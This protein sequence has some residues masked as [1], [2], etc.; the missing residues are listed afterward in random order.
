PP[1]LILLDVKMPEMDGY[2]VCQQLQ[3]HPTTRTI[4]IIFVTTKDSPDDVVRG[5]SL[6]AV[7]F[8]TKPITPAIVRARVKT[9]LELLEA[10]LKKILLEEKDRHLELARKSN[11]LTSSMLDLA[12]VRDKFD[13]ITRFA[14][15]TYGVDLCRVWMFKP[16]AVGKEGCPIARKNHI[17]DECRQKGRCIHLMSSC[18]NEM[19]FEDDREGIP[20]GHAQMGLITAREEGRFISNDLANDPTFKAGPGVVY[21]GLAAIAGFQL[22]N[23]QG[24]MV[25]IMANFALHPL[26]DVT[27]TALTQLATL[28]SQVILGQQDREEIEL[29]MIQAQA[30]SRAKTAFLATMS[31]EIRTPMNA[32]IGMASILLDTP[33]DER[34]KSYL[35]RIVRGAHTLLSVVNDILD[36]SKMEAGKMTLAQQPFDPGLLVE[37]VCS[38]LS[39]AV[40]QKGLAFA[41]QVGVGVPDLLLGDASR[42]KQIVIN[43]LGNAIKFTNSGEIVVR[44]TVEKENGTSATSAHANAVALHFLVADSGVGIPENKF[45]A[46]FNSFEQVENFLT[47]RHGGTGL[48]LSICTRLVELMGGRIW[49]ESKEGEGSQFHFTVLFD[50]PHWETVGTEISYNRMDLAGCRILLADGHESHRKILTDTLAHWGAEVVVATDIKDVRDKISTA[51][52]GNRPFDFL[53]LDVRFSERKDSRPEVPNTTMAI[54]DFSVI[55][56]SSPIQQ[57][58]FANGIWQ[59]KKEFVLLRP[60]KRRDLVQR[61]KEV[62]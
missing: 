12:P 11:I 33:L 25:G 49:V 44:V 37:D 60:V 47:R 62:R 36:F 61:L 58:L 21:T 55:L 59:R 34:Q 24:K 45:E 18:G 40:F 29:A 57:S 10:H 43:L 3:A 1:A 2:Q 32:V 35:G 20:F 46:I 26:D 56:V 54:F 17:F 30:A 42:L 8:I 38:T 53:L 22:R 31:H 14:V 9:H 39:H 27:I 48:G 41:C 15:E 13:A 28:T 19:P 52:E 5:L 7:D 4:P 16:G 50:K 6:G 23:R 51:R